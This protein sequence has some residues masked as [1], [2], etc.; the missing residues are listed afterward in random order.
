MPL[1]PSCTSAV[2]I[3]FI[4]SVP[5]PP[6][7]PLTKSSANLRFSSLAARGSGHSTRVAPAKVM[8]LKVSFGRIAAIAFRASAF[9]FSM[10]KPFIEPEVS[11]T[12]TSSRGRISAGATRAGGSSMS[13]K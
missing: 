3:A 6:E 10:G 4:I 1:R 13:A 12:N 9:D 8:K 5:P 11:S 2:L 7:R